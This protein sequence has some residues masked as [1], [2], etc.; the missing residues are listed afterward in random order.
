MIMT[1][2][3]IIKFGKDYKDWDHKKTPQENWEKMKEYYSKK[4]KDIGDFPVMTEKEEAE[5]TKLLEDIK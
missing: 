3:K 5:Y 1:E 2:S 4:G